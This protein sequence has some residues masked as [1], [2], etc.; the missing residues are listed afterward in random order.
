VA[1]S[2]VPSEAPAAQQDEPSLAVERSGT[3]AGAGGSTS[4]PSGAG[5]GLGGSTSTSASPRPVP[6]A[7]AARTVLPEAFG[8]PE[9]PSRLQYSAPA[10]D[11]EAGRD[12]VAVSSGPTGPS[13]GLPGH[14]AREQSRNSPCFCGSGRKFKR[15]HGDP[16]NA[17]A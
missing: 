16:R 12:G 3:P 14:G 17:S 7:P 6:T 9:Q 10:V 11:G 2:P 1:G 15:C 4:S 8:R 5:G 13:T